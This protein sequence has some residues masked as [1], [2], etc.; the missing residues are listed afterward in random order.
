M[1]PKDLPKEVRDVVRFDKVYPHEIG[2]WVSRNSVIARDCLPE[3]R[4]T[5]GGIVKDDLMTLPDALDQAIA[6]MDERAREANELKSKLMKAKD[7][8]KAANAE[9]NDRAEK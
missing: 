9:F 4:A 1:E 5:G 6:R 3:Y 2:G 7:A 8:L